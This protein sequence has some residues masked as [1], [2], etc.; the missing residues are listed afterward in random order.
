MKVDVELGVGEEEGEEGVDVDGKNLGG[1]LATVLTRLPGL[2]VDS[3]A[4]DTAQ[5]VRLASPDQI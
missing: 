3:A 1:D 4:P 2:E 5:R